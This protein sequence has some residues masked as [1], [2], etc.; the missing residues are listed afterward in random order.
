MPRK[1]SHT[2]CFAHFGTTPTNSRWSWSARN[3]QARTVVVTL[4]KHEFVKT[5]EGLVYD[6]G[7]TTEE[8]RARLGNRELFRDLQ[9]SVDFCDRRLHVIIAL[10]K[11]PDAKVKSIAEC[12]PTKMEVYVDHLDHSDGSFRLVGR[13]PEAA[14]PT[15]Q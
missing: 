10:A 6:R 3:E 2:E 11:D 13:L 7:P 1:L 15:K 5:S 4:W 12:Y 9:W 8:V 14:K